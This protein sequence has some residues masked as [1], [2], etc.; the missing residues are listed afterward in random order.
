MIFDEYLLGHWT[1]RSQAQSNPH[2]VAQTEV[3]WA[4]E[5]DWYTSLN[6]YRVD[7]PHKPYRN[8]KHKIEIVSDNYVIMQN[9]RLDGSRHGECDMH[10]RFESE[11]WSGKLDSDKCRGEKGYRVV[12]EIYLY[13]EKLLSR[14]KG[15]NQQGKMVWGSEEMYKFVRI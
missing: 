7:G 14:D 9:Y 4:K 11:H 2:K 13:G 5:G 10:F 3:I 12:S 15:L 1:N 8:K 6:F